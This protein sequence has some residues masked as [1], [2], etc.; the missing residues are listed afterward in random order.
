MQGRR[1]RKSRTPLY[2]RG[3]N[4]KLT[5]ELS[6]KI[7]DAVRAGN[8]LNVAAK[9]A[10]VHIATLLNW[11]ERGRNAKSRTGPDGIYLE[12]VED[13]EAAEA[14][15]E[16]AA[17]LHWRS[18]MPK[19]W[20][21]AQKYLEVTH[22]E[23]WAPQTDPNAAPS[24]FAGVNVNIGV[25]SGANAQNGAPMPLETLLEDNPDL[26]ASTMRVLDE[27]LPLDDETAPNDTQRAL[28]ASFEAESTVIDAEDGSWR[29]LD[30][31]EGNYGQNDT[32]NGTL[33][34]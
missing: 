5:P 26:I 25:N 30:A 1:P 6:K 17:V 20:K 23:R 15:S 3:R 24:A 28:P 34:T 8:Y 10:G 29:T 12:F 31:N 11:M 32:E 33:D 9:Y 19:D 2:V 7:C 22:R 18:A 21:A 4:S 13:V 16:V 27:F 14:A